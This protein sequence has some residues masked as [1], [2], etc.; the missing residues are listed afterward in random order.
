M[1]PGQRFAAIGSILILLLSRFVQSHWRDPESQA[2]SLADA[3]ARLDQVPLVIGPWEGHAHDLDPAD[4]AAARLAGYCWREYRNTRT[5]SVV[6]VLLVCGPPGP[7]SV[8]TP[9]VCYAGAGYQCIGQP[10]RLSVQ[11]PS[12]T[13]DAVFWTARFSKTGSAAPDCLR[14]SW[15]WKTGGAW[16]APDTPRLTFAASP[17]LYKLYVVCETTPPEAG[18]EREPSREFLDELLPALEDAL[19]PRSPPG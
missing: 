15:A 6:S 3:V 9:D 10:Q 4:V 14:I 16:Q 12:N 11:L 2:A 8:H 1:T 5:G 13:A 18:P 17:S 7:V 19:A